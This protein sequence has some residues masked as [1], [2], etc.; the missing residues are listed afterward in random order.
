MGVYVDDIIICGSKLSEV[1]KIK[2]QIKSNFDITNMG[3]IKHILGIKVTRNR[4]NKTIHLSQK[5]YIESLIEK[6]GMQ[7]SKE[8]STP[9]TPGSYFEPAQS[10]IAAPYRELIGSLLHATVCTRPDI[11]TAVGILSRHLANPSET[12]WKA[13]KDIL[14]YL[15]GTSSHGITLGGGGLNLVGYSDAD[16]AECRMDRKS[17]SG[18]V[19]MLGNGPISWSSRKQPNVALSST[20]AEYVALSDATREALWI[21]K[22]LVDLEIMKTNESVT[23][24]EDNQSCIKL[25]STTK[26]HNRTK[27]FDIRFHF[28]RQCVKSGDVCIKYLRTEEM[29]ADIFTKNLNKPKFQYLRSKLGMCPEKDFSLRGRVGN[30]AST[31][32]RALHNRNMQ[33]AIP[34]THAFNNDVV[35]S[36]ASHNDVFHDHALQ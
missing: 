15:K 25:T 14:R 11:A 10:V 32:S 4:E 20:E 26:F 31:P 18:S 12:H 19:F 28:T 30:Q 5:F 24:Y 13:A 22:I 16:W 21:K 2:Q 35:H 7:V 33:D 23:I 29:I 27:H 34:N 3:E 9:L 6:F 17:I 36:H 8:M 1:E